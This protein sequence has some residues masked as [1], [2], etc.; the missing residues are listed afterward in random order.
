[1][2]KIKRDDRIY[3][4]IEQFQDFE[5]INN[6]AFE[7]AV[8]NK[9]VNDDI[10]EAMRGYGDYERHGFRYTSSGFH[11]EE[12]ISLTREQCDFLRESLG[13]KLYPTALDQ[14]TSFVSTD[15]VS[16][17]S[18]INPEMKYD[19]KIKANITNEN[20]D[21]FLKGRKFSDYTVARFREEVIDE[22]D[23]LS[24]VWLTDIAFENP[25]LF[26]IENQ[27]V[28][29]F[30]SRE[31]NIYAHLNMK[32]P[33][34]MVKEIAKEVTITFNMAFGIDTLKAQLEII[35]KE[36]E[37]NFSKIKSQDELLG[38]E[39]E[40]ADESLRE[41]NILT[42]SEKMADMFFIH[43]CLQAGIK[44]VEIRHQIY[45]HYIKKGIEKPLDN[46]TLYKYRDM[47]IKYIDNLGYRELISG[48]KNI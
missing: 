12:S 8:R 34:M 47:A 26:D 6:I 44:P 32:R 46:K 41:R 43:D 2:A 33:I 19:I 13:E 38:I 25:Y 9:V 37:R 31:A 45:E 39:L 29:K 21:E 48:S 28:N 23:R 42:K 5:L 15:H 24:S 10:T 30:T 11:L 17:I 1:M 16:F 35:K 3:L 4:E 40:K 22:N 36:Y 18:C 7:M 27:G 20:I 14:H